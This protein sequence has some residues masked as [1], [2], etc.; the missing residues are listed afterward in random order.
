MFGG[1]CIA[2]GLDDDLPEPFREQS[3]RYPESDEYF[4][5]RCA[6]EWC[7][8]TRELE[9]AFRFLARHWRAG[10]RTLDLSWPIAQS[11]SRD[12]CAGM[13]R[14]V[15]FPPGLFPFWL[16]VHV[17]TPFS[18]E[19][20]GGATTD[21]AAEVG[22]DLLRPELVAMGVPPL[23]RGGNVSASCC[24]TTRLPFSWQGGIYA[25]GIWS[26]PSTDSG[27]RGAGPV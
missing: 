13:S 4:L 15:R 10:S 6:A 19:K 27:V 18:P 7:P 25:L 1:N 12:V 21:L 3:P 23:S 8:D 20:F 9:D 26:Q 16:F 14:S 17:I 2:A 24:D 22:D 5:V 11:V